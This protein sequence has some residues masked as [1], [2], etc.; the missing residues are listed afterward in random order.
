MPAKEASTVTPEHLLV[1]DQSTN[2]LH[3]AKEV[4]GE[5]KALC[6]ARYRVWEYGT[7]AY[8]QTSENAWSW[9]ACDRCLKK[10]DQGLRRTD[11]KTEA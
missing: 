10:A 5:I 1:R 4:D 7:L 3:L 9:N 6:N 8:D 2:N 11:G